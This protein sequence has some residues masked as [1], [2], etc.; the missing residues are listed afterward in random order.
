[1]YKFTYMYKYTYIYT[2]TYTTRRV[3]AAMASR[4]SPYAKSVPACAHRRVALQNPIQPSHFTFRAYEIGNLLPDNQ[5]Q[6]RTR[7]ALCHI[8]YRSYEH[9]RPSRYM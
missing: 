6:R 9:T 1:M 5:R 2:Y 8:L 3:C 4:V 7:H